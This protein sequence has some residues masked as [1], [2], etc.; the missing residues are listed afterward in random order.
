[1]QVKWALNYSFCG[2]LGLLVAAGGSGVWVLVGVVRVSLALE[3]ARSSSSSAA[4][5]PSAAASAPAASSA[6][7]EALGLLSGDCRRHC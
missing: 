7:R 5:S 3:L 4:S 2:L 1:M 6:R